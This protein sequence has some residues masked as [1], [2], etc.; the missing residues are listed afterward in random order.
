MFWK[1]FIYLV[2]LKCWWPLVYCYI[3]IVSADRIKL[4]SI[5]SV[6]WSFCS[7]VCV[8]VCPKS[9]LW[10]NGWLDLESGCRL[11]WWVGLVEGGCIRWRSTCP[12]EKGWFWV[13]MAY[14]FTEMYL[15]YVWWKVDN[16]SICTIYRWNRQFIGFPEIRSSLRSMLGFKRSVQKCNSIS[17]V[18]ASSQLI[19]AAS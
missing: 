9:V 15:T 16:I 19:V 5:L 4:L 12:K 2:S 1:C 10:Q 6:S 14:L 7:S 8:S 13:S 18:L 17:D 11:G 3:A